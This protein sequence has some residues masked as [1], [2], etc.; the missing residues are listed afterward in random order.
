[1]SKRHSRR[2]AVAFGALMM[3]SLTFCGGCAPLGSGSIET[4]IGDLIRNI[5]A[6]LV[7]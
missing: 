1:M 3:M 5:V 4:F 7:L 2:S 6:A